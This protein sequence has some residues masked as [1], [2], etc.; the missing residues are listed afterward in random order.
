[1]ALSGEIDLKE[2]TPCAALVR[3]FGG[4]NLGFGNLVAGSAF[5]PLGQFARTGRLFFTSFQSCRL[6]LLRRLLFHSSGN[7]A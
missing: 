7:G 3:N 1:L 6:P 5:F 2:S 4:R